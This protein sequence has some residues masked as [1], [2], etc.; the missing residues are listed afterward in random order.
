MPG[1]ARRTGFGGGG[2]RSLTPPGRLDG[3]GGLTYGLFALGERAPR[4]DP[5]AWVAPGARLVGDVVLLAG[6]SVWYNAVLRGDDGPIRIGR[7]SNVQ[8]N[9]VLHAEED[10]PCLVG[11]DVVIGHLAVVHG[12]TVGD[13]A[14]VGMG[15]IILNGARVGAGAIVAAGALVP[16]GAEIPAG[17]L[18][19][20]VPARVVRPVRQEERERI[21][22]GV[23]AYGR[24]RELHRGVRPVEREGGA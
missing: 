18:A 11:D 15:A 20:G 8:D 10:L 9:A 7:N 1:A 17:A 13:G 2:R 22:S 4:V 6:A 21:R 23:A 12:C 14:L 5:T 16:E 24:L 19:V 3:G